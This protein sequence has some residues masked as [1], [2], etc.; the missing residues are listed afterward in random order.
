MA[1]QIEEAF[2][3]GWEIVMDRNVANC[4]VYY[5]VLDTSVLLYVSLHCFKKS[6]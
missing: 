2:R 5:H 3:V 1:F 6:T 4:L